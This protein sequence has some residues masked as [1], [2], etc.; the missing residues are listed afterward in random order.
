MA[1]APQAASQI[2][3]SQFVIFDKF[4]KMNTKVARQNLPANQVAWMENLQ[5]IAANDLQ[6]VPGPSASLT[7]LSGKTVSREFPANIGNTDYIIQ[8][9][10]D[11]SCIAV[12]ASSGA[13]TVIAGPGAFSLTPDMTVYSSQRILIIDPQG[14]YATWD[15]TLL[16]APTQVSPNIQGTNG[17]TFAATPAVAITGGSGSGATATAIMGGSGSSQF[18]ASIKLTF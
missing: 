17:G 8:F 11:G 18:V 9:N 16:I 2:G 3:N 12:N 7:T 4:E 1:L 14:G 13:Q 5:P 6:A 10:T 15:G